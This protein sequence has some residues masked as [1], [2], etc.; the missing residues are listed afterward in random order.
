MTSAKN[1]LIA[2]TSLALAFGAFS[3]GSTS[4]PPPPWPGGS[5]AG[6]GGG[7]SGVEAGGSSGV[8]AGDGASATGDGGGG[9][10]DGAPQADGPAEAASCSGCPAPTCSISC[11]PHDISVGGS[12]TYYWNSNG[13]TC[14][15][16]CPGL[17]LNLSV[18]CMGQDSSHFQNLQQSEQCTLTATGPGGAVSCSDTV[19]VQ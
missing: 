14:S 17:K 11:I 10:L 5:G 8:E 12:T 7:S 15:L 19:N 3:C 18:P 9:L 13:S 16:S 2:S 1:I 4:N 6:S